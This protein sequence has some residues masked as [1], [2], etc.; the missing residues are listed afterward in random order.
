[1]TIVHLVVTPTVT[2]RQ[3]DSATVQDV[4]WAFAT[5]ETGLEH[6][7]VSAWDGRID[8]GMFCMARNETEAGAASA[9]VVDRACRSSPVLKGWRIKP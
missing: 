6:V 9:L 7:R 4:I 2:C 3:L 8:I 5:I 1:M